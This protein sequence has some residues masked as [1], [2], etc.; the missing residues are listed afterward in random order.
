MHTIVKDRHFDNI[1][2]RS[3]RRLF[4]IPFHPGQFEIEIVFAERQGKHQTT[5]NKSSLHYL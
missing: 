2:T 1:K 5:L 4:D 3:I